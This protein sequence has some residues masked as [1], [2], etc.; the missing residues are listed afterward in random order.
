MS[1]LF[2]ILLL[3]Y[4]T[5]LI[6]NLA[7]GSLFVRELKTN[8]H[9]LW[10]KWGKPSS[11]FLPKRENW[12]VY[13]FVFFAKRKDFGGQVR[14]YRRTKLLMLSTVA[15]QVSFFAFIVVFLFG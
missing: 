12:D 14:F 2:G 7:S 10:V 3:L 8:Q 15:N 11:V 4:F 9:D 1:H 5:F 6:V 13:K